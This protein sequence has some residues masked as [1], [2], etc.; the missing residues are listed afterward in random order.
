ML[1]LVL[2][3]PLAVKCSSLIT[4]YVALKQM[5]RKFIE[6]KVNMIC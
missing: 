3:Q 6:P 2:A 5:A 1:K 4:V